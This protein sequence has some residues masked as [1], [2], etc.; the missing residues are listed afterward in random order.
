MTLKIL[1]SNDKLDKSLC[2]EKAYTL[3]GKNINMRNTT[4]DREIAGEREELR[5]SKMAREKSKNNKNY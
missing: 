5:K 1:S 4:I 2:S 3:G